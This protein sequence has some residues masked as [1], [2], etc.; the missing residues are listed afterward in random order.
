MMQTVTLSHDMQLLSHD[1][2]QQGSTI[3]L[4]PTMG[5]LHA[6]H[7]SLIEY[8]RNHSDHVVVSIFVNPTQFNEATDFSNYPRTLTADL[9]KLAALNID[10]VFTPDSSEVYPAGI[11]NINYVDLSDWGQVLTSILEGEHRPGH[12]AGMATIVK[13]LFEII[14]PTISVF[15]EKDF[16]QL[17]VIKAM[18]K[19]MKM[20]VDVVG[21]RTVREVNGLAM[22]SRNQHLSTAQFSQAALLYATLQTARDTVRRTTN[23]TPE[24]I[25]DLENSAQKTLRQNG[26]EPEYFT[27]R[28]ANTLAQPAET[29]LEY[30]ILTAARLGSTRL[31]D[32]IRV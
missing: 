32:N 16:Q 2:Q 31:I 10:A 5:N 11:E 7:L 22:S 12:F 3:A 14:Q 29:T 28:D 25:S 21:R 18:V 19:A 23:I 4:V 30:V 1:W 13:I 20:T 8:A 27:L 9:E 6:G 15:G 17:L 26:F 24:M